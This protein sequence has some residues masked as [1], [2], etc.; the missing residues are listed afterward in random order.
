MGHFNQSSYTLSIFILF[1]RIDV[2]SVLQEYF[3]APLQAD[4]RLQQISGAVQKYKI[5][6]P[7]ILF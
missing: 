6:N 2:F 3:G 5:K 7:Q 1:C 4:L